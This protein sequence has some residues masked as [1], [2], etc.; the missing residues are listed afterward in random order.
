MGTNET[1]G[2]FL[3]ALSVIALTDA[4]LFAVPPLLTEHRNATDSQAS[5]A[6]PRLIPSLRGF[7]RLIELIQ[8]I[9]SQ[10]VGWRVGR[11]LGNRSVRKDFSPGAF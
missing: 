7:D 5:P 4:A 3:T 11:T 9:E 2:G 6:T 1:A 8:F 10:R